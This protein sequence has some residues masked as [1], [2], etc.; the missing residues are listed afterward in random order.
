MSVGKGACGCAQRG[1]HLA[2]SVHSLSAGGE[3]TE[4]SADWMSCSKSC[5]PSFPRHTGKTRTTLVECPIEMDLLG[6]LVFGKSG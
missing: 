4:R 3:T 6:L 1:V 5:R 2:E